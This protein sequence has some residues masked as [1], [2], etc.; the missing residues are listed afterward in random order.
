MAEP[1]SPD[2]VRTRASQASFYTGNR[3]PRAGAAC[4]SGTVTSRR[5]GETY[6]H[7]YT[8]PPASLGD[9]VG[10]LSTSLGLFPS[11]PLILVTESVVVMEWKC[12]ST[13]T[14][15]YRERPPGLQSTCSCPSTPRPRLIRSKVSARDLQRA[16][17]RCS[18]R[19]V[20]RPK[21]QVAACSRG[22]ASHGLFVTSTGAAARAMAPQHAARGFW[23]MRRSVKLAHAPDPSCTTQPRA[24]GSKLQLHPSSW[25]R[26]APGSRLRLASRTEVYRD[27]GRPVCNRRAHA[28]PLQD[29]D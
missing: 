3:V 4:T 5:G 23:S 13:S 12:M 25:D 14:A 1:Y 22:D 16:P 6:R 19:P 29:H 24:H 9:E 15:A 18:S 27:R 2:Q 7:D 17:A 21:M 8:R 10:G 11:P 20:H 28:L 26:A